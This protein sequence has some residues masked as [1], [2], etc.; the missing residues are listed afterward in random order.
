MS[1]AFRFVVIVTAFLAFV[2]FTSRAESWFQEAKRIRL[3]ADATEPRSKSFEILPDFEFTENSI[4]AGAIFKNNG[5]RVIAKHTWIHAEL[6]AGTV[7]GKAIY[8][9]RDR[10]VNYNGEPAWTGRSR[11]TWAVGFFSYTVTVTYKGNEYVRSFKVGK[12]GL[13]SSNPPK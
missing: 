2:P 5:Q 12:A 4:K 3:E 7:S 9:F 1:I 8:K 11:E 10:V 6:P 13:I